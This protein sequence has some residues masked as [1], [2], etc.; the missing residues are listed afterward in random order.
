M[1]RIYYAID[2]KVYYTDTRH[3]GSQRSLDYWQFDSTVDIVLAAIPFL[4]IAT[5]GKFYSVNSL[6]QSSPPIL[7]TMMN[8]GQCAV[9]SEVTG[10]DNQWSYFYSSHG[11][12]KCNSDGTTEE[13]TYKDN[14]LPTFKESCAVI[15]EK[16]GVKYLLFSG[17][18]G[19]QS[20]LADPEYNMAELAR[21][22]L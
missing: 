5:Q 10:P 3:Y 14:A 11:F 15:I 6:D 12:I 9:N 22:S 2:D 20:L 17:I 7:N 16:D 1:G 13:V 8:Y 21:G 18:D 19:A 4:F